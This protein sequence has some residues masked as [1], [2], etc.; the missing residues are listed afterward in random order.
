MG[1]EEVRKRGKGRESKLHAQAQ[2]KDIGLTIVK[3]HRVVDS[4]GRYGG[5][6]REICCLDRWN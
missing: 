3:F 1:A 4:D 2:D 6:L 5:G